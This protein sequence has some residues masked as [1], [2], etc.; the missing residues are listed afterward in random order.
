MPLLSLG[1]VYYSIE[2]NAYKSWRNFKKSGLT[3]RKYMHDNFGN[4]DTPFCGVK[5][6]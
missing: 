2:V 4:L 6:R 1:S 5:L 3:P